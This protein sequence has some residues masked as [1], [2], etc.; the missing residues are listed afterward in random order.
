MLQEGRAQF[1]WEWEGGHGPATAVDNL[2]LCLPVV[3]VTLVVFILSPPAH[4]SR[5]HNGRS[6]GA[7][8]VHP[9]PPTT[10]IILSRR[11]APSRLY[12]TRA[13]SMRPRSAL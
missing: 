13:E 11:P 10:R 5:K 3:L 7:A 9:R 2:R 12:L 4:A 1:G 6:A 8:K